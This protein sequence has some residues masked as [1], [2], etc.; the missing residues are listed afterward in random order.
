MVVAISAQEGG[1][2]TALRFLLILVELGIS[3]ARVINGFQAINQYA[4]GILNIAERNGTLLEIARLHLSVD[5]LID[6]AADSFFGVFL[7]GA[8]G[9]FHGIAHHEDGCFAIV[10]R[11]SPSYCVRDGLR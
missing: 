4:L 1:P 10:C 3:N 8:G 7:E 11:N 6:E 9:G 2:N 5:N